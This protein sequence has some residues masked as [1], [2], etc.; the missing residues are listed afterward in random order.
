MWSVRLAGSFSKRCFR[1]RASGLRYSESIKNWFSM[2]ITVFLLDFEGESA[3]GT[4]SCRNPVRGSEAEAPR[5]STRPRP[6]R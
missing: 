2:T 5:V 4:Q 1:A 3:R 6:E